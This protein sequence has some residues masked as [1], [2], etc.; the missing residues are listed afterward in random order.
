MSGL[1]LF[2]ATAP[3]ISAV[4]ATELLELGIE[5]GEVL[6]DG[7]AFRGD[8]G[9]VRLANLRLRTA[10]RVVARMGAFRAR[11]FAELER[12][13]GAL[14]WRAYVEEGGTAAFRVTARKCRLFQNLTP[15]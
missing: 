8:P 1:D 12:H 5:V 3:G 13:A 15:I 6:P 7:V 2:A 10:N 14:N 11:T 4:T 9:V